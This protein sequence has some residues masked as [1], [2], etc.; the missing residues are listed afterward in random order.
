MNETIWIVCGE[1]CL[2]GDRI[3]FGVYSTSEKAEERCSF[4]REN[5]FV[6]DDGLAIQKWEL[7]S[8]HIQTFIPECDLDKIND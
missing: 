7:N 6:L 2:L 8:G 5:K 3:N 4:L 1:T